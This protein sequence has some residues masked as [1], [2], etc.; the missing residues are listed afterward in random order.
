MR[1]MPQASIRDW[2]EAIGKA[3]SSV[4]VALA[5]L[6][7]A[8]LATS[9]EGRWKLTEPPVARESAAKWVAPLSAAQSGAH[10]SP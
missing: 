3:R 5:R 4:D 6:R 7:D 9:S 1:E 8:G 2:A 10:V